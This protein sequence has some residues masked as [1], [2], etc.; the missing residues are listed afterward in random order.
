MMCLGRM[1]NGRGA[2]CAVIIVQYSSVEER[3]LSSVCFGF[4]TEMRGR[5]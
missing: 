1:L 3:H 5:A 2:S 4:K